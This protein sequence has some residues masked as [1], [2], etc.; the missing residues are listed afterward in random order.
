M[1]TPHF[2]GC[3][4]TDPMDTARC[5]CADF[6]E[7]R[8]RSAIEIR[9]DQIESAV[10]DLADAVH[11]LTEAIQSLDE[12]FCERVPSRSTCG[13]FNPLNT[14]KIANIA[15][16]LEGALG[17]VPG[18]NFFMEGFQEALKNPKAAMDLY[19]QFQKSINSSSR[20]D[21]VDDITPPE[22]CP[23]CMGDPTAFENEGI[24]ACPRCQAA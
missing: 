14:D 1:N 5:P 4:S 23:L 15:R 7:E 8:K 10:G 9:L 11:G 16:V 12:E 6:Y 21:A 24:P 20:P 13:P 3:G 17:N 18:G 2:A 22:I 19:D